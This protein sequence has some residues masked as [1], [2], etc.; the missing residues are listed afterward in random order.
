MKVVVGCHRLTLFATDSVV[1]ADP[2][3]AGIISHLLVT[4][5]QLVPPSLWR[6]PSN[7]WRSSNVLVCLIGALTS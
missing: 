5:G 6:L 1:R 7:A 3:V 4:L 2:E